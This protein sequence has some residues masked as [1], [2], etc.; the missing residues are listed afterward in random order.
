MH[1]HKLVICSVT[2]KSTWRVTH[3]NLILPISIAFV[4][5]ISRMRFAINWACSAA[6]IIRLH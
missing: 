1:C 5:L 3:A 4:A 2:F 6:T